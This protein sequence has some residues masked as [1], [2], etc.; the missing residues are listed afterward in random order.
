M[1]GGIIGEKSKRVLIADPQPIFRLGLV[2]LLAPPGDELN[3]QIVH[4]VLGC[5]VGVASSGPKNSS[6]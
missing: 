2:A 4:D 5:V 1:T 3:E 6:S